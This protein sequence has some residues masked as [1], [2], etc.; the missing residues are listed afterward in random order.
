MIMYTYAKALGAERMG[1]ASRRADVEVHRLIYT[2]ES[3]GR[4]NPETL[5]SLNSSLISKCVMR[6]DII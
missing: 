1:S 6:K 2:T 5:N 4:A 3:E